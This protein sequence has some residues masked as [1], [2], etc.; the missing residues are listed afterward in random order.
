MAEPIAQGA[1]KG[2]FFCNFSRIF[3][4]KRILCLILLAS[5][6]IPLLSVSIYKSFT[7]DEAAALYNSYLELQ[8]DHAFVDYFNG[9]QKTPG[10][11]WLCVPITFLFGNSFDAL[12]AV[13]VLSILVRVL[14]VVIVYYI[15]LKLFDN[16]EKKKK[17]ALGAALFFGISSLV[18]SVAAVLFTEPFTT[19]LM[20]LAFLTYISNN[21]YRYYISGILIGLAGLLRQSPIIFAGIFLFFIFAYE[22]R[23]IK[24][25]LLNA[26]NFVIGLIIGFSP[27][28]VYLFVTD[29]FEAFYRSVFVYQSYHNPVNAE[30]L[31][32]AIGP[33]INAIVN[34]FRSDVYLVVILLLGLAIYLVQKRFNLVK[35]A[36][37]TKNFAANNKYY[38]FMFAWLFVYAFSFVFTGALFVH[39]I[40]EIMVPIC[41]IAS[42]VLFDLATFVRSKFRPSGYKIIKCLF[43]I[44]II[45]SVT[46][47]IVYPHRMVDNTDWYVYQEFK[48]Y[49]TETVLT[50]IP[51]V[52]FLFGEKQGLYLWAEGEVAYEKSGLNK[53]FGERNLTDINAYIEKN[54]PDLLFVYEIRDTFNN[55]NYVKFNITDLPSKDDPRYLFYMQIKKIIYNTFSF[56]KEITPYENSYFIHKRLLEK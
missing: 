6:L 49:G 24:E 18:A 52:M 50:D 19:L 5:F 29:S 12:L 44:F 1:G 48:K 25:A 10:I 34:G 4:H 55:P 40:Y 9:L 35:V 22:F 8:G 27:M 23:K 47:G 31:V 51:S 36:K 20:S 45:L 21:K 15:G 46:S 53:V 33:K 17:I 13:R 32:S 56:E 14:T 3:T 26:T 41:L 2:E 28:I 39:Y 11:I 16:Y 43:I 42:K 7:Y 30:V 54:Q 38:F 37:D